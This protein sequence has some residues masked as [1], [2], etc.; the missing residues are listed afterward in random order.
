MYLSIS[1]RY[2]AISRHIPPYPALSRH[3]PPYPALS[4]PPH[5]SPRSASGRRVRC[6]IDDDELSPIM[7]IE[8]LA[9]RQITAGVEARSF[10]RRVRFAVSRFHG[11]C[12][13]HIVGAP[14]LIISTCISWYL[15]VYLPVS[16]HIPPY[17]AADTA[18]KIVQTRDGSNHGLNWFAWNP[19]RRATRQRMKRQE[20]ERRE[21][22]DHEVA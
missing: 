8:R 21:W 1:V 15:P 6:F 11:R 4:C 22:D 17:P 7:G 2:P 3:I 12:R 20:G 14:Y 19:H 10:A 13:E 16:R 18:K 9:A 5:A